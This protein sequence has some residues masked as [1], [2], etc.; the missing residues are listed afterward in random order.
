MNHLL[1]AENG[2]FMLLNGLVLR[3]FWALTVTPEPGSL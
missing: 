1:A 2:F 3:I